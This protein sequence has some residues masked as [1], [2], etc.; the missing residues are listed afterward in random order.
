MVLK[1]EWNKLWCDSYIFAKFTR[2]GSTIVVTSGQLG[3]STDTFMSMFSTVAL[4][5]AV[6][7]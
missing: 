7:I 3:G 5:F 1:W 4:G 2:I 6:G